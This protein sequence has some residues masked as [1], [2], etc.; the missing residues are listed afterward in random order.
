M[1]NFPTFQTTSPSTSIGKIRDTNNS[2]EDSCDERKNE[3]EKN[4]KKRTNESQL[5]DFRITFSIIYFQKFCIHR[6]I[7]FISIWPQTE[8]ISFLCF[9]H[10]YVYTHTLCDFNRTLKW[11]PAFGST[12]P[13]HIGCPIKYFRGIKFTNTMFYRIPIFDTVP[14]W[15]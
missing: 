13:M 8:S 11:C 7:L 1:S 4:R 5:S 12:I 15:I 2:D 9:A 14:L 3:K 6:R 10:F